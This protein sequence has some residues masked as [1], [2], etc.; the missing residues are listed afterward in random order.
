MA[1]PMALRDMTFFFFFLFWLL[2]CKLKLFVSRN[3]IYSSK[4]KKKHDQNTK[5]E[6]KHQNK[7]ASETDYIY[8]E[9][10]KF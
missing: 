8:I 5:P 1:Q 7:K 10:N 6:F 2:T 4:K 9:N 3:N